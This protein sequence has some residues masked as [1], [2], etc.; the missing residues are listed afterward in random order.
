MRLVRPDLPGG[1]LDWM[2]LHIQGGET[3]IEY[4]ESEREAVSAAE[5]LIESGMVEDGDTLFV[6]KIERQVRS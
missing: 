2:V 6:A 4:Y 1:D 3:E 5:T